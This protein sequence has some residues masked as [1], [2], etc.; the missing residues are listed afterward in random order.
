MLLA[1][2]SSC[3][4]KPCL[5]QEIVRL[6][7]RRDTESSCNKVMENEIWGRKEVEQG[8]GREKNGKKGKGHERMMKVM[9]NLMGKK[10]Y[11]HVL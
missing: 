2:I 10:S 11:L 4:K 9:E 1:T 3:R 8:E 6:I 7:W 5:K